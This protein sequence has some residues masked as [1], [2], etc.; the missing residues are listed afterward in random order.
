VDS[1][2]NVYRGELEVRPP[3]APT[4]GG[5]E[6]QSVL[7]RP[8]LPKLIVMVAKKGAFDLLRDPSLRPDLEGQAYAREVVPLITWTPEAME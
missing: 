4:T 1:Q 2:R 8:F 6:R 3:G 5:A 7:V